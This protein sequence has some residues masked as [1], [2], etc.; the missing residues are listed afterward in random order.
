MHMT[1]KIAVIAYEKL[2]A[3]GWTQQFTASGAR[4]EEALENYR[5]LGFEIK[6]VPIQ[7]LGCAGCT[8][9]FDD[10]SDTSVMIFT[11]PS[12]KPSDDDLYE[13]VDE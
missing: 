2:K 5:T 8:T 1:R 3:E 11:R 9:C 13:S 12:G 4:L 10:P 6:T 7:Q